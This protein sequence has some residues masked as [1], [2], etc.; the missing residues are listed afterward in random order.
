MIE[1]LKD[2]GT[3]LNIRYITTIIIA[4]ITTEKN[5]LDNILSSK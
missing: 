5:S 3:Q 1:F 4:I 2:S